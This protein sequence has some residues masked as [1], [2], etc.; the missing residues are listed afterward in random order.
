MYGELEESEEDGRSVLTVMN[1]VEVVQMSE[2]V[3]E[4][5]WTSGASNDMIADSALALLLG[6]D[7]SPATVKRES[8]LLEIWI[9]GLTRDTVTANPHPHSHSHSHPHHGSKINGSNGHAS[10]PNPE[11]EKLHLF[12]S[13][14]FGDVTLPS[15]SDDDDDLLVMDVTVDKSKARVDLISMVS[16]VSEK[17]QLQT[18]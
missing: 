14:H 12:L 2:T 11:F 1:A 16:A 4:L 17:N 18:C 13:A 7:S 9:S 5:R 10:P 15:T 8:P 6:I 3:A